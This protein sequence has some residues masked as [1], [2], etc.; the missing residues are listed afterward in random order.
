[1]KDEQRERLCNLIMIAVKCEDTV[2]NVADAIL[3]WHYKEMIAMKE[4]INVDLRKIQA[5]L[6]R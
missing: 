1:M 5:D 6:S 4:R 2:G 3:E